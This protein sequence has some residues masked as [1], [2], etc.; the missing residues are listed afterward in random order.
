[1]VDGGVFAGNPA[2]C[3]YAQAR[4]MYPQESNFLVVSL[5][6]GVVVHNRLCSKINNW[7]IAEWAMPISSVVL[8]SSSA[9]VDYQMRAL[10][11]NDN[12]IRFQVQLDEDTAKM[13][14][15]SEKNMKRLVALAN[16]AVSQES[17]EIDRLCGILKRK[18]DSVISN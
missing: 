14:N 5:G 10:V 7:G 1:M 13:D 9:T 11:G 16:E 18:S 8:N 3:A 2:V 12:Y 4:N 6:T 15:A 17:E